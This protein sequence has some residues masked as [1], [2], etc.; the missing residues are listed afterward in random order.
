LQWV[1]QC[2]INLMIVKEKLAESGHWYT[3]QGTP[4]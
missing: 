3:K 2:W 1:W 4:A